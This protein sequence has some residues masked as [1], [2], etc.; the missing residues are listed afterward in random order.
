[1][2]KR[3]TQP[4]IIRRRQP[5]LISL[6][7]A[8]LL[9]LITAFVVL[10]TQTASG[11]ERQPFTT[12]SES[13][14]PGLGN[15]SYSTEENFKT[16]DTVFSERGHS[17]VAMVNGYLLAIYSN[18][19]GGGPDNG[20]I[21]LYDVSDPYAVNKVANYDFDLTYEL[22][23]AH[24]IS[25]GTGYEGREFMV[26]QALHGLQ[27]WDVTDAPDIW[28]AN[29]LELPGIREDDYFGA[30]WIFWQ[31]PYIY[32]AG[33][34]QGLYI[35]DASSIGQ[36]ELVKVIPPSQLGGINPGQIFVLGNF[37][38][39][40]AN[41][42][43]HLATFDL[44]DPLN[45]K[46]IQTYAGHDAYS[47]NF[48][49]GKIFGSGGRNA[50]PKLYIYDVTHDG[51]ISEYAALGDGLKNG[52]YG[53]YQDGYYFSGF[54]TSVA[55]FDVA[56]KRMVGK[57]KRAYLDRDYDFA[58][59]LGNLVFAGE[60]HYGSSPLIVHQT[61]PDQQGPAV[62]WV[63]PPDGATDQPTT[64]RV[65]LSFSDS[66]DFGSVNSATFI[67]RPVNGEPLSGKYSTQLNNANFFPD[68]PLLEDYPYEIIVEGVL[69]Y[70]GNPAPRFTSR[71]SVGNPEEVTLDCGLDLQPAIVGRPTTLEATANLAGTTYRWRFGD[72][73]VEASSNQANIT[74]T[75]QQ[76]GRYTVNLTLER[77]EASASCGG[78]Q[79][80]T[81]APSTIP[82]VH[83]SP[84]II[85]G[86]MVFNV[87][88]DNGT[89]T[90]IDR[91][92]HQ[93]RWEQ[94]ACARPTTVAL[95]PQNELWVTCL[96][97][98]K[99]VRLAAETGLTLGE[100]E[101][102]YGDAPHSLLFGQDGSGYLSLY[103]SGRVAKLSAAGEIVSAVDV[104]P[105]PRGLALA[106]ESGRLLVS[107][108]ISP[109]S[110]GEVI[111]IETGRMEI[112]QIIT[113]PFDPGPD[114]E[115]GGRGVPNYI[116]QIAISPDSQAA[117]VPSKKDNVTRGLF[118][119]G[120]P[121]TFESMVR[122]IASK[123]DLDSG[124]ADLF[125]RI[126][127]DNEAL[128]QTALYSPLGDLFFIA[129][130]GSNSIHIYESASQRLI[131]EISTDL[132][133]NGMVID[134]ENETLFV[135][136]FLS[137]SV[138]VYDLSDLLSGRKNG[139]SELAS[140]E[141]VANEVLS[142]AVL[143]GKEIFY[144]A[145]DNQMSKDGYISCAACHID[146]GEDGRTWDSTQDAEGLRNTPSLHGRAG[147]GQGPLHWSGAFDEVQDVE[148][149]I[150][151][152]FG[153]TGFLSDAE[154][155]VAST[156]N[157]P[158]KGGRS[159]DLDALAA[160]VTSLD[161]Y[162]RS[163]LRTAGGGLTAEAVAG[164]NIFQSEGC[165]TCH[166]GPHFTDS[167]QGTMH[168]IGSLG[169]GSGLQ[170]VDTPTL[171]DLWH[172]APYLHDGSAATLEQAIEAHA[173][174]DFT[175][176]ELTELVAYLHQIDQNEPAPPANNNQNP[177]IAD[178]EGWITIESDPDEAISMRLEAS[179]PD[180]GQP[181]TFGGTNLPP[182]VSV[183]PTTGSISGTTS[184]IGRY[185]VALFVTDGAGGA[186]VIEFD[187]VV[188]EVLEIP[189]GE[190]TYCPTESECAVD[191]G[192]LSLTVPAGTFDGPVEL[193]VR[194]L[195]QDGALA[196][197]L[198]HGFSINAFDA[199]TGLPAQPRDGQ[200]IEVGYRLDKNYYTSLRTFRLDLVYLEDEFSNSQA[201][202]FD[203]E[204][205]VIRFSI[206]RLGILGMKTGQNLLYL[207]FVR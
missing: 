46:L 193:Q 71:F 45:P 166:S 79:I 47:H 77:G 123:I 3:P 91:R 144:N 195:T 165:A 80:V 179:D 122:P 186:D 116:G 30:W 161:S 155:A 13:T 96:E 76:P 185:P 73:G 10:T 49:A 4:H 20:G 56:G 137:R 207:P 68:Q 97:D 18:D 142:P 27:I 26:L 175:A 115:S 197:Q 75:Y 38:L 72:G 182:G 51:L 113:L 31:A 172:S 48:A 196:D 92:S 43:G 111:E 41:T 138:T 119:D 95:S 35:I 29:F 160:Y 39:S 147:M 108:F 2:F 126:D 32:L 173:W 118:K 34:E 86:E 57:W 62:E 23:E 192:W 190:T 88:P 6:F 205:Q 81:P 198:L 82:P 129:N 67:V 114:Q 204:N 202:E 69:D 74:T 63:H 103:G 40:A 22:R 177:T 16:I 7:L 15:L 70:V 66:I 124:E 60:D 25:F 183:D 109:K 24:S 55:K 14:K 59:V 156:L 150:R 42:G 94:A 158:Q 125:D 149:E 112:N 130:L 101:L 117:I 64:T 148:N 5:P 191:L 105:T 178:K 28:L 36:A 168:H 44:G 85:A 11:R 162:S 50:I 120:Q 33:V 163:P 90:A 203:T 189:N 152:R 53:T 184:H 199:E 65:G 58:V 188:G 145:D 54:S 157:G 19:S 167:G 89:V 140:V 132:A 131:S 9:L 153:G 78:T 102:S 174:T 100:I 136:N 61:A 98:D 200:R 187:W 134:A 104:G 181:L 141:T 1:M 12:H 87:N 135:H 201:L 127:L 170:E 176:E 128:P 139:V 17:S 52:G 146:G 107:R 143:L 99:L 8:A 84:I 154:F 180:S 21:D 159:T 164:R 151:S 106:E 169:P 110:A 121:L 206:N 194:F 93:K 171:R 37:M 83:A 133:P